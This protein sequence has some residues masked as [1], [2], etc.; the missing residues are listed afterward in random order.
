MNT[1]EPSDLSVNQWYA[2][3]NT[4]GHSILVKTLEAAAYYVN[5]SQ[6]LPIKDRSLLK[7]F[8]ESRDCYFF[9]QNGTGLN[10]LIDRYNMNYDSEAI[11]DTF[12]YCVRKSV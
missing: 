8:K 6:N 9:V 2:I 1:P 11:R 10:A 4:M 7:I 5:H 3:I 12:N